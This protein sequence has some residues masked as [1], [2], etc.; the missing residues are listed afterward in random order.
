MTEAPR[1][2]GVATLAICLIG[3]LWIICPIVVAIFMIVGQAE[4]A[5][6]T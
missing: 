4:E 6:H 3:I 1:R 5:A 2:A